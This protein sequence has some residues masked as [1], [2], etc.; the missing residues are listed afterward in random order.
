MCTDQGCKGCWLENTLSALGHPGTL[1]T[2]A[3]QQMNKYA[4]LSF[5]SL[6]ELDSTQFSVKT[7]L[8]ISE[9]EA[10]SSSLTQDF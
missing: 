10:Y 4:K 8:R 5:D 3:I 6:S 2:R 1:K 9:S 7:T